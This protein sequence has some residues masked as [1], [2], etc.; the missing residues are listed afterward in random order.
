M[1]VNFVMI[2]LFMFVVGLGFGGFLI[3]KLGWWV[4]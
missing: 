4:D 3:V 1:V 2:D